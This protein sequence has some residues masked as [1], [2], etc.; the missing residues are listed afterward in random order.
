[1]SDKPLFRIGRSH[2]FAE[3]QGLA[4]IKHREGVPDEH[5]LG[6]FGDD[7]HRPE[8]PQPDPLAA[9][10]KDEADL[11]F[12]TNRFCELAD[13]AAGIVDEIEETEFMIAR[14]KNRMKERHRSSKNM[15]GIRALWH[16]ILIF[17]AGG[18]YG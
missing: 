9:L 5:H 2:E 3:A 16:Q 17:I 13:Q 4:G 1:M 12:W 11:L 15:G 8:P 18:R 7:L 14:I 6:G 10:R